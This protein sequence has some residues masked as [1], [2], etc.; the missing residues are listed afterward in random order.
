MLARVRDGALVHEPVNACILLLGQIDGAELI[1]VEDLADG[2]SC[3]R[4][5]RR[6]STA[7]ARNAA[8][9][10]PGIVMSLFALYQRARPATRAAVCDRSPAICAAAPAT[11]RSSRR[12]SRPAPGLPPTASPPPRRAR[13]AALAA[14]AD[15]ADLF[16]GDDSAFFAAPASEAA[17]GALYARHPDA[18]LLGGA[19]DVGLWITKQLRDLDKIIWLGRVAGLDAIEA[20]ADGLRRRRRRDAGAGRA[21]SRRARIPISAR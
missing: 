8:S 14:L 15:G 16:V 5:S 18:V 10:R 2:A 4:C 13:A 3:I 19:T 12:R 20:T 9:A 17:L 11:A 21:A 6:W 1:T 7:T